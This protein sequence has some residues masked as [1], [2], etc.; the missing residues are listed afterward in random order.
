MKHRD[1]PVGEPLDSIS[2]IQF[3]PATG[4][5]ARRRSSAAS[6]DRRA[7]GSPGSADSGA[8]RSVLRPK[9]FQAGY[10]TMDWLNSVRGIS[11]NEMAQPLSMPAYRPGEEVGLRVAT[12]PLKVMSYFS[13]GSIV[14]L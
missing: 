10:L 2:S 12:A 1:A 3:R 8:C 4:V 6:S 14:R 11:N 13:N 7:A 9:S 5:S